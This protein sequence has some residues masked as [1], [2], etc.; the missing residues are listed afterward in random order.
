MKGIRL[1]EQVV[2]PSSVLAAEVVAMC[3]KGEEKNNFC[4]RCNSNF[5]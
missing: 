3:G 4:P 5:S 1:K 2:L